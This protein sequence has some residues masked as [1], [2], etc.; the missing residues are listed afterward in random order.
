[1]KKGRS[2]TYLGLEFTGLRK[3]ASDQSDTIFKTVNSIGISNY[4]DRASSS[5]SVFY[6][7]NKFYAA[8]KH[9]G[10]YDFD[11]FMCCGAEVVPC[12]NELFAINK[13]QSLVFKSGIDKLL[14]KGKVG[15]EKIEKEFKLFKDVK[16]I[17]WKRQYHKIVAAS[18]EDAVEKLKLLKPLDYEVSE[19]YLS[20]F[21]EHINVGDVESGPTEEIIDPVSE[22][23]IYSAHGK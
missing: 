20:D 9:A 8:A 11:V 21:E 18:K 10:A 1:M 7:Y 22:Q 4:S 15:Q 5:I 14:K 13:E 2:F 3:L 16:V 17:T 12:I 6:S 23:V 19:E